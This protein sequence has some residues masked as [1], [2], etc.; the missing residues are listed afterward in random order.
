MKVKYCQYLH[1]YFHL[2]CLTV[3]RSR[4]IR[5]ILV[6]FILRGEEKE[7]EVGCRKESDVLEIGTPTEQTEN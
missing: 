6:F 7:E 1:F 5:E 4:S 3:E 2:G